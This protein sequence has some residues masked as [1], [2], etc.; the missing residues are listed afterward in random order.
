MFLFVCPP[1]SP[2]PPPPPPPPLQRDADAEIR[3]HVC[4]ALL[5]LQSRVKGRRLNEKWKL[6]LSNVLLLMETCDWWIEVAANG[7]SR[8]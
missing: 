4:N 7:D 2:P 3:E 1:P 5:Q 8:Q 6:M